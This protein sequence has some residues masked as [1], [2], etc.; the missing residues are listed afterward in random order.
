MYFLSSFQGSCIRFLSSIFIIF[1]INYISLI[2]SAVT[3]PIH[4]LIVFVTN[5]L[6]KIFMVKIRIFFCWSV[7]DYFKQKLQC[8]PE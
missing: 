5:E 6:M 7:L 4:V 2:W 1:V 3:N 8:V